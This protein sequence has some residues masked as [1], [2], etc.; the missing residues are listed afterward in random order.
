[1][2]LF[3][4]GNL[5]NRTSKRNIKYINNMTKI[6]FRRLFVSTFIL[7]IGAICYGQQV[8]NPGFED[9]SGAQFDGKIQPASWNVSNIEQVGI[10][11]NLTHQESDT[12]AVTP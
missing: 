9:W 8:P 10:K 12:R 5:N 7:L 6:Y 3:T 1:M 11:F 2:Q 4:Y